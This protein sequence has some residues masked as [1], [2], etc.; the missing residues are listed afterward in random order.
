V[1]SLDP[2]ILNLVQ[3]QPIEDLLLARLRPSLP[4]VSVQT[5]VWD[6][7]QFPF[8]L[9]RAN[10]DWGP[11]SGD[12]RFIDSG[13][14]NIQVYC[15]GVDADQDAALLSE[16]VRV[17]M[18]NSINKVVPGIGHLTRVEQKV[19]ARRAADWATATGPVQYADLPTT[20]IRYETVYDV[21]Y[22]R[23]L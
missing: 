18:V 3:F 15:D 19:R 17:V 5:L 2:S 20:V 10:G 14:I 9:V 1:T 12:Q 23:A 4:G 11:W 13:Q 8:V 21:S 16:A 6:D 7:Q 22:K